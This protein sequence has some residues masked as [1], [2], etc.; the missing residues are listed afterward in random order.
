M[1][2]TFA[3][4]VLGL[5]IPLMVG[6]FFVMPPVRAALVVALGSEMFLP[7][8]VTFKLPLMPYFGK[9]TLPYLCILIACLLR[10]P[11]RVTK[12]P[13]EK[14]ILLLALLS[15]AGG[16][17]TS[18]YNTDP[19]LF[20]KEGQVFVPGLNIKDGF[21]MGISTFVATYLPFYL[22]YALFRKSD[23]LD[24]LAS[25]LAIAG[26]LYI[27]FALVELRL[28]PQWHR[29]IYGYAQH[30]FVQTL[31]PGGGYRPMVFMPHGLALAQFFMVATFCLVVLAKCRRTLVGLPIRFLAWTQFV[32]LLACKSFGAITFAV[33]GVPLLALSKPKRQLRVA[34]VLAWIV[35]CYP[36]LRLSGIF[37]VA[38]MLDA[39]ASVQAQ[40]ADSLAFRFRHEDALLARAR[41]RVLFGWGQY[42]RNL[43]H[44]DQGRVVSVTD[45]HWIICVSANGLAGFISNF[46]PL[47][48]PVFLTRRHLAL[49][50]DEKSKLVMAGLAFTLTILTVDL[51]PNGLWNSYPFLIGG[52]L[53]RRSREAKAELGERES[54][55]AVP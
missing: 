2:S 29:W 35:L 55:V 46:A 8:L 11:G 20:G 50:A 7:E 12:P 10:C 42:D 4:I 25:G 14:W 3:E 54:I 36:L 9:H 33:L 51:I 28:S 23:D 37:P 6:V 40:R 22:G 16:V 30:G 49:L 43:V 41:E 47:L 38:R 21:F 39:F 44:N 24:K 32:V 31:R 18:I 15:I 19:L 48:I 27:P 17:L 1:T 45:G 52:A 13:K 26:L 34:V 5:S 53:T